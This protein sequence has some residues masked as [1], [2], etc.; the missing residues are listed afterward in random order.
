MDSDVLIKL[1]MAYNL[2][3]MEISDL[4]NKQT[5]LNFSISDSVILRTGREAKRAY[6]K[7]G[8]MKLAIMLIEISE[9]FNL[10]SEIRDLVQ[11]A[12][13]E[14][15]IIYTTHLLQDQMKT[16]KE[17]RIGY[18][19]RHGH[20]YLPLD[21]VSSESYQSEEK[22]EIAR[23]SSIL[24]EFPIGFLFF[25]NF[26]LLDLTQ[27]EIGELIGKSAATV[28]LV[29]KQMEKE[30]LVVKIEAGYHLANLENYFD[31][32][33]FIVS[34]F[35]TKNEFARYK[36][37]LSDSELREFLFNRLSEAK[38]A[39]SGA[40]IESLLEDG[41]LEHAEEFSVFIETKSQKGLMKDLKLIPSPKGEVTLYPSFID[42]RDKGQFAHEIVICAEL[43][44][45]NNPR[46]REA[47][48]R[49][50]EK[51]LTQAK[52]VLNERFGNKYI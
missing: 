23:S 17:S 9:S 50:F 16:L 34:Q 46:I 48:E 45:S 38:W 20:F 3:M 15:V 32:W 36:T 14:R 33:R 30:G 41:Y 28:N 44:N 35:K 12:E 6:L 2:N 51:Y 29:L 40:R 19:D 4:I 49:R 43:F 37:N 52:K 5:G 1:N 8:N 11:L 26:G 7:L 10:K 31:R 27:A 25:K 24:N 39:L 47:G 18:I 13:Y 42:L 21:V 22:R